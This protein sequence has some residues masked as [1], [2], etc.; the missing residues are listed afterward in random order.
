MIP[1]LLVLDAVPLLAVAVASVAYLLVLAFVERLVAPR[2]VEL[3]ARLAR[4]W[5]ARA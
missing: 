2:D 4:H 3:V 5:L 1:L